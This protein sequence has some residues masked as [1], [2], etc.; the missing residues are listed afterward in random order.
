MNTKKDY[1]EILG[2]PQNATQCEIRKALRMQLRKYYPSITQ[3]GTGKKVKEITEAYQVLSN[4]K[5]RSDYD[6]FG[7][8]EHFDDE[9]EKERLDLFNEIVSAFKLS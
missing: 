7:Y 5:K 8:I 6:Q 4:P 1:Y 2:V 9:K 3:P